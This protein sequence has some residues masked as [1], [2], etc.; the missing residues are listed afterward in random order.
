MARVYR[1]YRLAIETKYFIDSLLTAQSEKLF[2]RKGLQEEVETEIYK[3]FSDSLKGVAIN[4]SLNVSTG[5]I[6]DWA[7]SEFKDVNM[8]EFIS[9]GS[10]VAKI[11]IP[12]DYSS[13]VTPKLLINEDTVETIEQLQFRLRGENPRVPIAPYIIKIALFKLYKQEIM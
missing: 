11:E 6:I 3:V 12:K 7:I 13:C 10:E 4:L 9:L 8:E 2:Q 5:S 1:T